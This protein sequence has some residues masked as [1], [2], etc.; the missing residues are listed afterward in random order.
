MENS[1]EERVVE[2]VIH[3]LGVKKEEVTAEA[4][5]LEDLGA[6]SL[7]T[8]ELLI[9]FSDEFGIDIPDEDAE[10]ITTVGAAVE[11]IKKVKGDSCCAGAEGC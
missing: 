11:Y 5:F 2:L 6:D 1:I 7:D 3:Q 9:T 4:S 8:V 10:S